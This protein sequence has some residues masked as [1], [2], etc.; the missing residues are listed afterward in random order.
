MFPNFNTYIL[1]QHS[2]LSSLQCILEE[3]HQPYKLTETETA[4]IDLQFSGHTHHGQV[5][6]MSLVTDHLFEQSHGYRQWG[7]SHIYVS[8]G[9]S[10]WGPPFRIGT[11]SEMV[12]FQLSMK[13]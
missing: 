6:P 3:D 12:I 2:S 4:G 1:C 8:S 5:W 7:N 9:L 11:D 10:L 13:K